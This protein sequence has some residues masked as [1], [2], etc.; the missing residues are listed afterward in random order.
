MKSIRKGKMWRRTAAAALTLTLILPAALPAAAA[1][2]TVGGNPAERAKEVLE[3]LESQHVSAPDAKKLS[4]VAIQAMIESLG[5]PYTQYFTPEELTEF[6][7]AVANRY[8]GIGVRVSQQPDGVYIAEVFDGPAREAGIRVG[9]VIVKVGEQSV[10]GAPLGEATSLIMGE[11]GTEVKLRLV[12]DGAE[13]EKTV[14]RQQIQ[15]PVVTGK[16][17]EGGVAYVRVTS[18]SSDADEQVA[19]LLEYFKSQGEIKGLIVDLRDNP[20][21]LLDTAKEMARLFVKEGTLIHTKNRNGLDEPVTFSGGEVQPFPVYMMVNGS[22]ASASEVL[23]GALQDYKAAIAI[24]TKT[25]GKGSVQNVIPL[26]Q[27]GALKVTVEEYLT[28]HQRPV[29]R[30]GLEPDIAVEGGQVPE[31]L[32]ALRTAGVG[33]FSLELR[34]INLTVN[35][36]AVEDSFRVLREGGQTY[37]PA[38]VL[39]AV[40]GAKVAWD[41]V[42]SSAKLQSQDGSIVYA[43]SGTGSKLQDGVTYVSLSQAAEFFRSLTW[44]DDGQVLKLGG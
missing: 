1:A 29:N 3:K 33:S 19:A 12:R 35:G 6:E 42:T 11:P 8:V 23:T 27:G 5:D 21:G 4:D 18:F 34:R 20:G 9:D 37:V 24:G 16:R 41:A 39:A 26:D 2:L 40:L 38:R 31:L 44:S 28:P 13:L 17:F 25:Y 36:H 7:N 10:V 14:K 22:S 32:T 43:P 30:V 15:V